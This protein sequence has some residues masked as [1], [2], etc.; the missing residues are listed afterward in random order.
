M[1]RARKAVIA[2]AASVGLVAG[3]A[4]CQP[5]TARASAI[6]GV[7]QLNTR[8]SEAPKALEGEPGGER[9]QGGPDGGT[10]GRRGG[11]MGGHRGGGMGGPEGGGMG[12]HRGGGMGPD[13]GAG[14]E[15]GPAGRGEL[16]G[17]AASIKVTVQDQDVHIISADGRVRILTPNGQPVER[18]RGFL[19]VSETARWTEGRLVVTSTTPRGMILTETIGPAEDGGGR[20]VHIVEMKRA[21]SDETRTARWVYDKTAG[22]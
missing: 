22:N 15:G 6:A 1:F 4:W 20:L 11:G 19:T 10:G 9:R 14:R 8:L 17:G 7:W 13:G 12:G 16:L 2:L 18:E 5:A 3:L 21:T